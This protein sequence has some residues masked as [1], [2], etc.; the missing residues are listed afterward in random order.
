MS[1]VSS[2]VELKESAVKKWTPQRVCNTRHQPISAMVGICVLCVHTLSV[3]YIVF[4]TVSP[5]GC[6]FSQKWHLSTQPSPYGG[7]PGL[8]KRKANLQ[9]QQEVRA[10]IHVSFNHVFREFLHKSVETN[11]KTSCNYR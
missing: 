9:P 1:D 7:T 2:A 3:C 11:R 10:R 8:W 6:C 5:F 4:F